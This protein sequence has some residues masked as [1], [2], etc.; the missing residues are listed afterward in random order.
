MAKSIKQMK[1]MD[2]TVM[3]P[4][5]PISNKTNEGARALEQAGYNIKYQEELR[6]HMDHQDALEKGI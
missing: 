6:R 2:L 1:K 4:E 5:L 3:E